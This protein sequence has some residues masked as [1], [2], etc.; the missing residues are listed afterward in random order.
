MGP[1]PA[2]NPGKTRRPPIFKLPLKPRRLRLTSAL[3][4]ER[5]EIMPVSTF[6]EHLAGF[7]GP[8]APLFP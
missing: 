2:E 5:A 8:N 3:Q 4:V 6:A 7:R 1:P